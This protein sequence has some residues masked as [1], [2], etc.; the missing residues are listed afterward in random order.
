MAGLDERGGRM[1][2]PP[3]PS[4]PEVERLAAGLDGYD[5]DGIANAW[6][7][8]SGRWYI[9]IRCKHLYPV[10]CSLSGVLTPVGKQL[11]AHLAGEMER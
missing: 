6:Q 4:S 7:G 10:I 9:D 8:G 5:A 1:N 11:R 3:M 2:A